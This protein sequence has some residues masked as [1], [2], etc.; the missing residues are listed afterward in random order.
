MLPSSDAVQPIPRSY[1][2]VLFCVGGAWYLASDT[3]AGRAARGISSRFDLGNLRGLLAGCF[4]LFLLVVGLRLLNW[5]ATRDGSLA[6]VAPL[7]RRKG[8]GSE[9]GLGAAVGWGTA[10]VAVLPVLLTGHLLVHY[11][12]N[13]SSV[14]A[15]FSGLATLAV[16]ALTQEIAF[17]GY[18]FQKLKVAI[19]PSLATMLLSIV[20]GVYLVQNAPLVSA[21][22]AL[23]VSVLFG[24]LLSLAYMR[25][26][27]LWLGWGLNFAYRAAVAILFGLPIA[28]HAEFS[29]VIDSDT[30]GPLRLNGGEF[31]L[32]AAIL[33]IPIMIVAMIVLYRLTR[34]YAWNYTQPVIV[35]GGYEVVVAPPAAHVAMEKQAAAAPP[36]LVQIMATTPKTMSVEPPPKPE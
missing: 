6:S 20:F 28:G 11:V 15:L 33:T 29:S 4:T 32:D 13:R 16:V 31:G 14:G 30:T 1:Q 23:C 7:P 24:V 25:T 12:F 19:G 9:W 18:L 5:I 21:I 35:A 36:P 22:P 3:I 17:R 10:L 34:E 26:H 8:F 27:A 2:F